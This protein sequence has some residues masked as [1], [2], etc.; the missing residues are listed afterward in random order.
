M[1]R[2]LGLMAGTRSLDI[3]ELLQQRASTEAAHTSTA[4][5]DPARIEENYYVDEALASPEPTDIALFDDIITTG[6]HSRAAN[7]V[8]SR[9][10]PDVRV[11]GIF[12]ARRVF[13]TERT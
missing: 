6:A 2:I 1:L 10:F 11:L 12:I 3:R 5:R 4:P 7:A 9:R 13:P 8:M